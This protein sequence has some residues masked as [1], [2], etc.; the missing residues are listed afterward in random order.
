MF[1]M[2]IVSYFVA[3]VSFR[4]LIILILPYIYA[5]HHLFRMKYVIIIMLKHLWSV[6]HSPT[7][8]DSVDVSRPAVLDVDNAEVSADV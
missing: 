1:L 4:C 6:W 5:Y 3:L 2:V 8:V 7:Y